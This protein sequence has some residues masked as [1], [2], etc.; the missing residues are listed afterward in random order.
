MIPSNEYA[1]FH[2]GGKGNAVPPELGRKGKG[3]N[4]DRLSSEITGRPRGTVVRHAPY[5]AFE[6]RHKYLTILG[7][8]G[9]DGNG[10]ECRGA[11]GIAKAPPAPAGIGG[12]K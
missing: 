3:R 4:L 9:R 2:G 10:G 11:A 12:A 1:V 6:A 8:A 7:E 5:P